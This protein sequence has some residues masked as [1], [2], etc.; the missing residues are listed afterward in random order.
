MVIT[1]DSIMVTHIEKPYSVTF[2]FGDP[3]TDEGED[4]CAAGM[5]FVTL[6]EAKKFFDSPETWGEEFAPNCFS[7]CAWVMLD[8]PDVHEVKFDK[9]ILLAAKKEERLS[10][11]MSRREQAHQAGMMGGCEAYNEAMGY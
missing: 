9:A 6:G 11:D 1:E 8:G 4:C 3:D 7:G 2:W 5:D 10:G